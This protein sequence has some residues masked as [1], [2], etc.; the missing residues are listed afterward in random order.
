[1]AWYKLAKIAPIQEI[2]Q[3]LYNAISIVND[4]QWQVIK[5]DTN[6][7]KTPDMQRR[8]NMVVN[9][10]GII[11]PLDFFSVNLNVYIKKGP[12]DKGRISQYD[13]SVGHFLMDIG[14]EI[15]GTKRAYFVN[16]DSFMLTDISLKNTQL[17]LI[18]YVYHLDTPYEVAEFIKNSIN[19][20]YYGDNDGDED[21]FP[22][23]PTG[24]IGQDV[25]TETIDTLG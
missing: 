6:L 5:K 8:M 23:F 19:N 1:M 25:P 24:D 22:E 2:T 11:N 16:Q 18:G 20:Y 4:G 15:I 9:G 7:S 12:E 10:R 13:P 14:V 17:D 21:T 3:H